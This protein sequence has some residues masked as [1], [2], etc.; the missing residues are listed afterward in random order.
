MLCATMRPTPADR[1]ASTRLRVPDLAE[2]SVRRAVPVPQVGQ[3]V[4][5]EVRRSVVDARG[6]RAGV[7]DVGDGRAGPGRA[8]GAKPPGV[9]G[10]RG[11]PVAA[12][13]QQGQDPAAEDAGGAGQEHVHRHSIQDGRGARRWRRAASSASSTRVSMGTPRSPTMTNTNRHQL[14]GQRLAA[15]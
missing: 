10:H 8:Q 2:V 1:A 15:W 14:S 3:L 11:H 5:D 9:P 4:H 13:D 6:D 7:E 12:L